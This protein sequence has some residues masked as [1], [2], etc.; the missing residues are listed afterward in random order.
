MNAR[1]LAHLLLLSLVALGVAACG[2]FGVSRDDLIGDFQIDRG[3]AVETLRLT[4]DGK[5]TQQVRLAGEN[6]WTTR[7]GP[8][9]FN[10]EPHPALA[11]TDAM[12]VDDGTGKPRD[13]WRQPVSGLRVLPV[14]KHFGTVSLIVDEARG[15]TM[16]KLK[17]PPVSDRKPNIIHLPPQSDVEVK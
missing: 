1:H 15:L 8:W 13:G 12:Q 7:S 2:F 5:Y 11:L 16:A 6:T 17:P 9:T 14:K 3:Y 10:S 4:R